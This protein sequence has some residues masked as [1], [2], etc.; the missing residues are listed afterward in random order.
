MTATASPA[1]EELSRTYGMDVVVIPENRP[2]IRIDHPD[3]VFTHRSAK[4]RALVDEIRQVHGA[5]RPILV[6]TASVK[7]SE[8]LAE[9]LRRAGI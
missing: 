3:V 8:E 7:K 5:G 6:G 2:S 1:A 9:L 4:H